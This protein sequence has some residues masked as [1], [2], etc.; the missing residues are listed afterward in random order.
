MDIKPHKADHRD[1]VLQLRDR[2]FADIDFHAARPWTPT[3]Q[4]EGLERDALRFIGCRDGVAG[5]GAAFR[6]DATHFRIGLLVDPSHTRRGLGSALLAHLEEHITEQGGRYIQARLLEAM[7]ASLDFALGRGFNEIHRMRGMTLLAEDF[8]DRP[9]RSA[10]R[11]LQAEGISL[12]TLQ[13]EGDAGNAP[14]DRLVP[15]HLAA[16]DGWPEPDPTYVTDNSPE[17][18]HSLFTDLVADRFFMAVYNDQYVGYTSLV[19]TR[20]AVHPQFRQ[21][22][23]ARSMK[24]HALRQAI[25]SG[26]QRWATCTASPAMQRVNLQMG[27]RFNGVAEV[28]LVKYLQGDSNLEWSPHED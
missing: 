20:T 28:R 25:A 22:G 3:R 18:L 14:L 23:L 26:E 2:V 6:L 24:T 15:L 19:D 10:G 8:D 4:T 5:Y 7:P 11:R 13:A 1:Q 16:Q 12:T 27:Y 9:G 21:R 17:R